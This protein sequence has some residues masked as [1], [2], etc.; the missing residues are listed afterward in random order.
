[1]TRA[2]RCVSVAAV[3]LAL[4]AGCSADP[5]PPPQATPVHTPSGTSAP[6]DPAKGQIP[7]PL[8]DPAYARY[9]DQSVD[10]S[11]CGKDVQ[12]GT[13][14]VPVDW[15]EPAGST[16]DL[17]LARRPATG[18][19]MGS[20]LVNFGGPGAA[21][22]DYVRSS[23][24]AGASAR[25]VRARY[26]LVG[27][28]PRGTG[29]SAP[30]SCLQPKELDAYLAFDPTA[31]IDAD[32]TTA[33][34]ELEA[35]ADP[36]ILGCARSA[37]PLLANLDSMS[38]VYDM[39]VIRQAL[40]DQRLNFLG[41][42][43]GTLLGALYADTLPTRVGRFVL[44]GAVDPALSGQ[45]VD[46]GQAVGMEQ[47]LRAYVQ[48]CTGERDCPLTGSTDEGLR[49]IADLL[50]RVDTNPLP[51]DDGRPLTATLALTGI[52][53]P[54]YDDT[55]WPDLSDALDLALSGDGTGLLDLAD[56]YIERD[57][58]GQYESNINEAY[59]A[60]KCVDYPAA[61]NLAQA[62]ANAAEV[63]RAA[64]TLGRY[65][66]YGEVLC[67]RW[68]VPPQRQPAPVS[69]AGAPPILVIGTT[70]D[71]ATP[72]AWAQSLADE[73]QSGVLLTFE[74]EGHTAYERGSSCV[75]DAVNA[76]LVD[77]LLVPDG[78]VC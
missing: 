68:P 57:A 10:W 23:E 6:A 25:Q 19:R 24:A 4:V 71:P 28:D 52:I 3:A 78:T 49:Q 11:S 69:G 50:A 75:D 41:Y 33:L 12:C 15:S 39:D 61:Q 73:L 40:G 56:W 54:L 22:A 66:T 63:E 31:D 35:N 59:V 42:S 16:L 70:G 72:Y 30:I 65:M 74:G 17:A 34:R 48:W 26:D 46:V 7:D 20:L 32:P 8:T 67:A 21:G 5:K 27:F 43:Y 55:A 53:S 29:D 58:D 9:Y 45:Q 64:P 37:G 60:V 47:A 2:L 76:Y 38:V 44:D 36:F 13:V 18:Q 62:E 77:G 14:T 1:M 51:T